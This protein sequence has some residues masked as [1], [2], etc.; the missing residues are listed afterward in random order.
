M[1]EPTTLKDKR[2]AFVL[3]Y[4]GQCRFNATAAAR[5][6]GYASPEVEGCR[7][8]KNAKV[9][10]R[11]DDYLEGETLTAKAVLA[12]LTDVARAEW[13]DFLSIRTHPKTGEVVDVRMDLGAKV[14]SL[15]LL[16]KHHSLFTDNV[17]HSGTVTFADLFAAA[18]PGGGTGGPDGG[19]AA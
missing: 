7:L 6:A 3:A 14:K 19:G 1:A 8:L 18:N 9:R 4:I 15:E 10:A 13:R 5:H 2:E 11:I 17:N 16:G 12:E